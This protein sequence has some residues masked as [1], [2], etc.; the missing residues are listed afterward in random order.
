MNEQVKKDYT[1]P[2]ILMVV[3][4]FLFG[5][6][7]S[8]N[9]IV[10]PAL[11]K[12][13]QLSDFKSNLVTFS[14]F[15]GFVVA[16]P[17]A[18]KIIASLGY[19]KDLV[20]GLLV[21]ALGLL[22]F[23]VDAMM[24]PGVIANGG[25]MDLMYYIFL[26]ATLVVGSGVTILQVGAN[27]YVVALGDPETADSRGNTVGFFNSSATMIGPLLIGGIIF[28][29]TLSKKMS[30]AVDGLSS[31]LQ[32]EIVTATQMP[33]L[34]LVVATV[35]IAVIFSF[36]HLPKIDS[37][38]EEGEVV[39]GNPLGYS[40]MWQGVLAIFM[41]VGAEV[42]IGNN[43]FQLINSM[44]ANESFELP[45]GLEKSAFVGM[46]WGG[47]MVGRL[48]GIF[49]MKRIKISTGLKF[50]TIMALIFIT[51]GLV[52]T[53]QMSLIAFTSIGLFNSVMW[54][55]IFPLGI[56]KMGKLTN[57]ASGYMMMGVFGGALLP[58]MVGFIADS[59]GSMQMA[60]GILL[61]AYGYLFYY[62]V[63]GS[64]VKS[65]PKLD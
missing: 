28:S 45:F 32:T 18:T 41:Y 4:F 59:I 20:I 62:A 38:S 46:Y 2:M 3:I 27:P 55:A 43:L 25:N 8:I 6:I 47:A 16:S 1:K 60:Y 51:I 36:L 65:H 17:I 52:T 53:K 11:Q 49:V 19:K 40:H 54:P 31:A 35:I 7:T 23:Y 9:G 57:K 42:A 5:F 24:L 13:F 12:V 64:K 39:E 21:M 61:V 29:E 48:V 14:F 33:Y 58:L 10:Q 50:T 63:S 30:A 44:Q 34:V 15:T 26:F 37:E 56:A 22:I